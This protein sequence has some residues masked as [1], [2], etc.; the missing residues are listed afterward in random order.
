MLVL[1][2][3]SNYMVANWEATNADYIYQHSLITVFIAYVKLCN[4]IK[5]NVRRLQD[6][7]FDQESSVQTYMNAYEERLQALKLQLLGKR[8]LSNDV[9]L[10]HKNNTL[11][12]YRSG[13]DSIVQVLQKARTKNIINKTASSNREKSQK[14]KQF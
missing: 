7:L 8:R 10:T 13:C 6:A 12:S 11:Q 2:K 4:Y 1:C 9:V 14:T 5:S 3:T